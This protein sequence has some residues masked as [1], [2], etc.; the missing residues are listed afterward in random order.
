MAK[1]KGSCTV[2]HGELTLF[3]P[4]LN[5]EY[6]IC[7]HCA[8]LQLFPMPDEKHLEL[9]YAQQYATAGQTEEFS[10][11][12]QW[13]AVGEPYRKDILRALIDHKI[14]GLIVEFGAGWGQLC[15]ML[16]GNG[17]HC[18][19]V[20]LSPQMASYAQ[21]N[22]LPILNGG[23]EL[24][25][26][27]DFQDASAIVMCAVFEH[28]SNHREWMRRFNRRL[29]I[30]GSLVTLHPT[31]ACYTLLGKLFRFG[32]RC[33]ELPELHGSFSPPWHTA[34]FS[35][36]A[37]EIIAEQHGFQVIE[38]RPASQGRL[39]GLIG[40]V[41][42]CLGLSNRIGWL[43]FGLHWPLITTHVFVLRKVRELEDV[44]TGRLRG[45]ERPAA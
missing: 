12:N 44:P 34:L 8:T 24:V 40:F 6:H 22:G 4:R 33:T 38:I 5:Y 20:E 11:P 30:G 1:E 16:I 19:G 32:N 13:K 43:A 21:D 37:M 36:K 45:V 27:R 3:G 15:E 18:R 17:F 42:R 9:A 29:P 23:F 28:L 31:A 25:E 7:A 39:S 26:R 2:C 10:N 14:T 41:Q 35:L